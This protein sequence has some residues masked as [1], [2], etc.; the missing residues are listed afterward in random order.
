MLRKSGM[1]TQDKIKIKNSVVIVV[2][3]VEGASVVKALK[4]FDIADK[5]PND[6]FEFVRKLKS[7]LK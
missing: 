5:T 2:G 1:S 7:L 3:Q 6:C 4:Q